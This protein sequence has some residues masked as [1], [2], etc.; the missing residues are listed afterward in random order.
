MT[1]SESQKSNIQKLYQE[2]LEGLTGKVFVGDLTPLVFD[3]LKASPHLD[4]LLVYLD[5]E[6]SKHVRNNKPNTTPRDKSDDRPSFAKWFA[7]C[8]EL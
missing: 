4:K 6:N 7:G 5:K 3:V 2:E 8:E 1:I